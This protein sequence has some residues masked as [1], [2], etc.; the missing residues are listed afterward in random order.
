MEQVI[1]SADSWEEIAGVMDIVRKGEAYTY[2]PLGLPIKEQF[3]VS[4]RY[5]IRKDPMTGKRTMHSGVDLAAQYASV[6]YSTGSGVVIFSGSKGGYGKTIIVRHKYGF[7]TYYAHLTYLYAN[8][9]DRVERGNAI[10]FV[11]STGRS[12]GN[13]LHYEIRKQGRAINPDGFMQYIQ[14]IN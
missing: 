12:T 13:H 8:A 11:G 1:I 9:G 7:E 4:S 2:V 3:R 5:G 10:G 14:R 6:V